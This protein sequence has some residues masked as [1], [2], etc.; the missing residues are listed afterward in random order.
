MG[1]I[2]PSNALWSTILAQS[3]AAS[4]QS[5]FDVVKEALTPPLRKWGN[6]YLLAIEPSGS[7]A[8][9]TAVEGGTDVDLFCSISARV[10]DTLQSIQETLFNALHG[11]GYSPRYQNVSVGLDVRGYKVDVTPGKKRTNAG[12]DHSLFSR[13]SWSWIQTNVHK[14][15]NFVRSSGRV[16]EIR[17]LKRWRC[18]EGVRW[19]SFHLELFCIRALSGAPRGSR[20]ANVITV[21]KSLQSDLWRPLR[22]P[23]NSNN[24]VGE[25]LSLPEK[26]AL[27]GA[28]SNKLQLIRFYGV[29]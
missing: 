4:P 11:A 17:W 19:P 27:Q 6:G 29:D 14:H 25:T 24:D 3:L 20:N 8:K 9:G 5:P 10:P 16:P 28:A 2:P 1:A 15:I 23:A 18:A 12:N 13:K 22:D 21:L 26:M 7:F